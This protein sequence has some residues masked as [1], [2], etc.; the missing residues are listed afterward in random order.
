M[1]VPTIEVDVG[2]SGSHATQPVEVPARQ[3]VDP[4]VVAAPLEPV[5][6]YM[7]N[8]HGDVYT[9]NHHGHVYITN[10]TI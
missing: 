6:V 3:P 4:E 9:Y 2:S 1:E 5:D 7:Y 10:T 8:H